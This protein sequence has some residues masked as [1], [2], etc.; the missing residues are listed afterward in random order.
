MIRSTNE[1]DLF[2][3]KPIGS[4]PTGSM[5]SFRMLL[6]CKQVAVAESPISA[7]TPQLIT[8]LRLCTI[9]GG[10]VSRDDDP[11]GE[12]SALLKFDCCAGGRTGG[13]IMPAPGARPNMPGIGGIIIGA[14][15][16]NQGGTRPSLGA[17]CNGMVG[18]P[19][20]IP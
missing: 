19:H 14:G 5:S 11:R 12:L 20:V 9:L 10:N 18:R 13:K 4:T 15:G 7:E 17:I 6:S 2:S 3:F 8:K 16:I 1:A